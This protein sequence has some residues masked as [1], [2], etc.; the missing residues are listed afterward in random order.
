MQY[1]TTLFLVFAIFATGCTDSDSRQTSRISAAVDRAK[2]AV[3]GD[4][5]PET[6]LDAAIK[7]HGFQKLLAWAEEGDRRAQFFVS[8]AYL[9]GTAIP[10]SFDLSRKWALRSANQ[11][12]ASGQFLI[13]ILR[14]DAA[15]GGNLGALEPNLI[16]AYM[17]LSLAAAQGHDQSREERDLLQQ[18]MDP[19]WVKKAQELAANWSACTSSSCWDKEPDPGPRTYCKNRPDSILCP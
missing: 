12:S 3:S 5:L 4:R 10:K 1:Y 18:S 16:K 13:G 11:G 19:L 14:R 6:S 9:D 2:A 17:W 8:A 15:I 7:N